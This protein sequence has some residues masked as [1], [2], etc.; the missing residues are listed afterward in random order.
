MNWF[1]RWNRPDVAVLSDI[2]ADLA[3]LR[4]MVLEQTRRI[5][6]M[7]S[8]MAAD[9]DLLAQLAAGLTALAG[10]VQN[11]FDQLAAANA[12]IADLEGQAAADEAADL[13]A[14]APVKQAFDDLASKFTAEPE[15]P[16]VEPLPEPQPTPEPE[17]PA[18][19]A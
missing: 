10:P 13:D 14:I 6:R 7:E 18:E 11:L 2:Q 5:R 8:I 9:R 16:D 4:P 12:R 17:T 19:P 15:S 1:A 3:L